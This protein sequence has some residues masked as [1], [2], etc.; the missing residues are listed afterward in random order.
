MPLLVSKRHVL[1]SLCHFIE[2]KLSIYNAWSVV[3]GA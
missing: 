3:G 1:S 2:R